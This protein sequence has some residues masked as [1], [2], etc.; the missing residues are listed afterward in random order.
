MKEEILK[1]RLLTLFALVS[2]CAL[3]GGL[4]I[5]QAQTVGTITR[6]VSQLRNTGNM[7][8]GVP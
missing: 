3:V 7:A 5:G 2:F 1:Y 4:Q 6:T 8:S